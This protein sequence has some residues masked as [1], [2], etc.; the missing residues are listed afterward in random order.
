MREYSLMPSSSI[1][2]AKHREDRL[3]SESLTAWI[4]AGERRNLLSLMWTL[5]F[6]SDS[7]VHEFKVVLLLPNFLR[8]PAC[9]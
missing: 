5:A 3:Q 9:G 1:R 7:F 2:Y 4:T 6:C 8:K